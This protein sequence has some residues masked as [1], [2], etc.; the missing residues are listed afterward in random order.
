MSGLPDANGISSL[1]LRP[2]PSKISHGPPPRGQEKLSPVLG[3][4]GYRE[5]LKQCHE[6]GIHLPVYAIGGIEAADITELMQTGITGIAISGSIVSA[7][8]PTSAT[9]RLLELIIR[10]S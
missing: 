6:A 7:A 8:D 9:R 1:G 3:L 4:E 5:I 10:N 2:T